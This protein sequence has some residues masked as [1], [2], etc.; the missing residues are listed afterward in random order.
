VLF[1]NAR[2]SIEPDVGIE[3]DSID[4]LDVEDCDDVYWLANQVPWWRFINF[5]QKVDSNS[6][7][8]LVARNHQ[9]MM[10]LED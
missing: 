7:I 1:G 8:E 9:L 3:S 5:C 6:D 2:H 10:V 4:L